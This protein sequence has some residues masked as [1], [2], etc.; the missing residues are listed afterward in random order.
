MLSLSYSSNKDSGGSKTLPS[1]AFTVRAD[2]HTAASDQH[3]AGEGRTRGLEHDGSSHKAAASTRR[4]SALEN[5]AAEAVFATEND[6]RLL[7]PALRHGTGKREA[8]S[9]TVVVSSSGYK[10][11]SLNEGHVPRFW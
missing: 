8:V 9:R 1:A 11:P 6:A 3:K 5:P 7:A 2:G 4:A 10:I